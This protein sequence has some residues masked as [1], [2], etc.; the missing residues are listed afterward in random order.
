MSTRIPVALIAATLLAGCATS[1][2]PV[3]H[4]CY[5]GEQVTTRLEALELRTEDGRT[6]RFSEV[7]VGFAPQESLFMRTLPFNE[8]QGH[9]LEF[10]RLQ[11]LL[12]LYD[13]NRD[14]QLEK[15]EVLVLYAREAARA[16]GTRIRHFGADL[17]IRAISAP[18]ADVGGLVGWVQARRANMDA[19]GQALFR[20]LER[21][22]RDLRTRTNEGGDEPG[23]F[24]T[25]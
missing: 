7:F 1:T 4:C 16:T 10:A 15:P 19:E 2:T 17:P 9:E 25:D 24:D 6:L 20:D 14:G 5:A 11:P 3:P 12:P 8:V 22:G 23:I 18:P 21:L 13:A